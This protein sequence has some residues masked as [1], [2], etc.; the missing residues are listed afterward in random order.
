[1]DRLCGPTSSVDI[2]DNSKEV[3]DLDNGRRFGDVLE[4]GDTLTVWIRTNKPY[5]PRAGVQDIYYKG[6]PGAPAVPL[7]RVYSQVRV[8]AVHDGRVDFTGTFVDDTVS[9]AFNEL[10]GN[11]RDGVSLEYERWSRAK[12]RAM[13]DII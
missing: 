10:Y 4:P 13:S 9:G 5:D 7:K 1:M 12:R 11:P 2:S 3:N 8:A 6:E